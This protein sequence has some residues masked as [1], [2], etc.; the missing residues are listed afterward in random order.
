M[1]YPL[2]EQDVLEA[3]D[4]LRSDGS[5][6]MRRVQLSWIA[7]GYPRPGAVINAAAAC[8]LLEGSMWRIDRCTQDLYA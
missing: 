7:P 5:A 1:H 8:W 2:E 6:C 4:M 3:A